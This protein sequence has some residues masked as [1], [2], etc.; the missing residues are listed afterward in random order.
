METTTILTRG[1]FVVKVNGR[2]DSASHHQLDAAL[3]AVAAEGKSKYVVDLSGV[4]YMSSAGLRDLVSALKT[5][6]R[7][8][9]VGDVL[10]ANPS[11]R[12]AEVL[13]MAGM[14]HLF[15]IYPTVDAAIDDI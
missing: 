6:K 14:N 15:S 5:A 10:I 9:P 7:R 4:E 8:I 2:V 1:A 12:A 13:S 11:E 3:K